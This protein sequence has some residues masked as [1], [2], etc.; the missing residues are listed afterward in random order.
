MLLK[1]AGLFRPADGPETAA[2]VGMPK[3]RRLGFTYPAATS[4]PATAPPCRSLRR[5]VRGPPGA[6]GGVAAS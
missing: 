1:E 5:L 4:P 3:A 6:G 2:A